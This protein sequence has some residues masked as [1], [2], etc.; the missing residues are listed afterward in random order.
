MARQVDADDRAMLQMRLKRRPGGGIAGEAVDHHDGRSG[1]ALAAGDG[2][3]PGFGAEG[4]GAKLGRTAVEKGRDIPGLNPATGA[5]ACDG[6]DVDPAVAGQRAGAGRRALLFARVRFGARGTGAGGI[7]PW[8][9]IV[10]HCGRI[11][12]RRGKACGRVAHL[13]ALGIEPGDGFA[14]WHVCAFGDGVMQDAAVGGLDLH[15]GLV[16]LDVEQ[17]FALGDG[18]ALGDMPGDDLALGHVHVDLGHDDFDGHQMRPLAR[19]RAA[20]RMSGTCGTT[21][22]SSSGL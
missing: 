13:F 6:V 8:G 4:G 19:L 9:R 20:S 1:A 18:I 21:A 22:F 15:R 3:R 16:G 12:F 17:R 14:D 5:G 11:R 2:K 7:R 10:L